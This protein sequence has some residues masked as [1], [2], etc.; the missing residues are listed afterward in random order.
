MTQLYIIIIEYEPG[1]STT[2]IIISNSGVVT[3]DTNIDKE[4]E[5]SEEEKIMSMRGP[6]IEPSKPQENMEDS[7]NVRS[8][9]NYNT[10]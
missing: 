4:E 5:D 8:M 9:C 7:N 6:T 2:E 10:F 1:P 3:K